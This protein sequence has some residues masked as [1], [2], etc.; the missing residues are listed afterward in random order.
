[1]K[2]LSC[3]VHSYSKHNGKIGELVTNDPD[4]GCAGYERIAIM[5]LYYID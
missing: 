2:T 3:L 4:N 5:Y 1:M